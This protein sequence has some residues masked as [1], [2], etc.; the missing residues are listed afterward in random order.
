MS[1][2]TTVGQTSNTQ[3]RSQVEQFS[4]EYLMPKRRIR[5]AGY[6]RVSD[7]HK[8][9]SATLESQEKEIRR[10][11]AEHGYEFDESHLY[12]EAMTAYLLPYRERPQLMKLLEAARRREFDVVVVT[13]FSRLSRRQTEQ[14]IIIS[15]LDDYGV[16]VESITEHF[17]NTTLGQFMRATNA[18]V[19]EVEREKIYWRTN[20]GRVDRAASALMGQGLP[21]YGYKW[22]DGEKYKKA[23][24]GL[25]NDVILVDENGIAW[26]EVK[27]VLF[28]YDEALQ[29]KSLRSIARALTNLGIPTQRKKAV[30]SKTTIYQILTNKIYTGEAA[31]FRYVKGSKSHSVKRPEEEHLKLPDGIVPQL[32]PLNTWLTVQEQ[33]ERNKQ[34]S[35]R[36]N[37]HPKTGLLRAGLAKCGICGYVMHVKHFNHPTNRNTQFIHRPEYACERKEGTQ[38]ITRN[39]S[40]A[41][42]VHILDDAAW[43]V[44]V[45]YIRNPELIRARVEEIR[46]EHAI[47]THTDII[48]AKLTDANKR[49]TNIY[50]LAE[51]ATDDEIIIGLQ[52]RLAEIEKEKLEL[53]G[54]LYNAEE[55]EE[56]QEKILAEVTRFEEW[57]Y[58]V[59]PLLGDPC[60]EP[61]YEEQRFACVILGIQATIFPASVKERI[62]IE[63][64]PPSIL[65]VVSPLLPASCDDCVPNFKRVMPLAIKETK[66][67]ADGARVQRIVRELTE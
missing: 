6:P 26:T 24:Y 2:E 66:G 57:V 34:L 9:D 23:L 1:E 5:A 15:I 32:I 56:L 25:N 36:N 3:S 38:D 50:R 49:A 43:K 20:R 48:Q 63:V 21:A 39:H 58:K 52:R 41:I 33:L 28:I 67:R 14:A 42:G 40:N 10:Y 19:A 4:W 11:V 53:R 22:V 18:Y 8:K 16:K 13:E 27:V 17:D 61:T 46:R 55:Q 65:R 45:E 44:A 29:G 62:T 30:W 54:L 31:N 35:A 12:P 7:H 51:A 47:D 60:Y 64:S 59:R 37:H